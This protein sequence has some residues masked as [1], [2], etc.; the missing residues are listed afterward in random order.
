MTMI[1]TIIA[2][3]P[4]VIS[5]TR[6]TKTPSAGG[7][8]WAETTIADQTVRLYQISTHNQRE[9]NLPEGEVKSI[10]LGILADHSADMEFGHDCYDTF[11][12]DSREY[13]I[14]GVRRYDDVNAD[15]CSQADCVAV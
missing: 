14:V 5:I 6:H 8:S 2:A 4:S 1:D 13:R 3:D 12:H 7:F 10:T 9:I 15:A 11:T